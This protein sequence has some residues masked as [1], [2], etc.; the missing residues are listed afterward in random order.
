MEYD[1]IEIQNYLIKRLV[2]AEIAIKEVQRLID[3]EH[4]REAQYPNVFTRIEMALEAIQDTRKEIS[5]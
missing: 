5:K 4:N 2:D 3:T 1:K